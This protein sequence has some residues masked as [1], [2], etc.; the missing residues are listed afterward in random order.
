MT[1]SR[2]FA[3]LCEGALTLDEDEV[4]DAETEGRRAK[5]FGDG[6]RDGLDGTARRLLN[7][8]ARFY[9]VV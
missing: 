2:E 1:N 3:R 9:K 4:V 8:S 7:D 5:R 6:A